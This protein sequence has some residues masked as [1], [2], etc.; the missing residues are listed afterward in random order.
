MKD[1]L[2]IFIYRHLRNRFGNRLLSSNFF[3]KQFMKYLWD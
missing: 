2:F 1:W 3:V